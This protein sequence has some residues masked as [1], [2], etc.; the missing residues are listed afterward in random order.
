MPTAA[1]ASL[2]PQPVDPTAGMRT[3]T[4]STLRNKLGEVIDSL[5]VNNECVLLMTHS[6]P[7]AVLVPYETFLKLAAEK[8]K[9]PALEFLTANYEALA[10]SMDTPVARAAAKDAFDTGADAFRSRPLRG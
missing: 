4:T 6:K 8:P 7:K 9:N 1:S 3:L 2:A 10:A 5:G